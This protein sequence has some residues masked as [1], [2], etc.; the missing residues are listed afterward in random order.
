MQ[1]Q[2]FI[3]IFV[4]S[5][6][7]V[8]TT[9]RVE[10]NVSVSVLYLKIVPFF[11]LYLLCLYLFPTVMWLYLS[12]YCIKLMW[13]YLFPYCISLTYLAM[14]PPDS[15]TGCKAEFSWLKAS[16]ASQV[17]QKTIICEA[18]RTRTERIRV[19]YWASSNGILFPFINSLLYSVLSSS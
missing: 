12:S 17:W 19:E 15:I 6:L 3:T 16:I 14:E 7:I 1:L 11:G 10:S 18:I 9:F 5:Y 8:C 4:S 13:L 2:L